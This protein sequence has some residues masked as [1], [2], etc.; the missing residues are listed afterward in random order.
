MTAPQK[1]PNA[2]AEFDFAPFGFHKATAGR[3]ID[4]VS[5]VL[6]L[7][8]PMAIGL[9]LGL[10][11]G[12]GL[13]LMM[14]PV[15]SATTSVLVSKKASVP[16]NN[17][18]AN[19]YGE[20]GDHVQL[21]QTDLIV[22]RAFKDH[23]LNEIPALANAYDPLR[24]VT[25]GLSVS[26]SAGQESSFDNVLSITYLH[27]DK[28]IAR[29]V[30]QAM[31]EA[32]RDYLED[33]RDENAQ[34]LYKSLL[35]RQQQLENDVKSLEAE[36]QKFRHDAPVF[37]KASP[38]VSING[39]PAPAQ[40]QYETELASI[41]TAQNENLRKR[42]S[43]QAR[44]ATLDRKLKDNASREELEF[45]VMHSLSTGTAGAGGGNGGG[46]ASIAG[47]PEKGALD[48]QL[49]TARLLEQRLLHSLGDDHTQVRNVRRQINT[50]LDF[51]T[52][53]GL[54]PPDLKQTGKG[55][56]SS[57][58]AALGLDLVSV[59][60]DTLQGQL[61]EL[62]LDNQNLALL[63][64]DA[65]KK[66][67]QAEMFEVEDQRRK[68]EI[69]QKKQQLER[70]FDQI[71]E[72]DITRG[73]E[74]YRLQQI[75]QVRIE[76]SMKRVI[77]LVGTCGVMGI[78]IIFCLAYF[79][80]WYDTSLK[81]LDDV[82]T[83]THEPLMGSVPTFSSSTDL[84]RIAQQRGLSPALCYYHR[85]GSREAEAYRSVRTTLF[86]SMREDH[87]VVQV[88]SA[89]P[90][91]GK[92]TT[93][94]NL[95]IAIAQSGK[96]VLLVDC[97][98]RRPTQ[99]TLFQVPQEVGLTDVLLREIDWQNAVRPTQIENLSLMTAGLC[100]ENPAELLSTG[101]LQVMLRRAREEYDVVLLDSPP[102]LAVSD[103]CIISP[104]ADGLLLVVRMK[105]TKRA[106]VQRVHETLQSHGVQVYGVIAN[107]FQPT[108]SGESGY[109][110]DSYGTYYRE[111]QT[112]AASKAK[113]AYVPQ[114]AGK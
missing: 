13:Y 75:S 60:R 77:K 25:E 97:D 46:G 15:Y 92:S 66:A 94:A 81:T 37:L 106:T 31:V 19:R 42:S 27:P 107:D 6:S 36:Y 52:R 4:I 41:E 35:E 54:T 21:I 61:K 1:Q 7:W 80:E 99:H 45:W 22:E 91:E 57:R 51:Y 93:A 95:A 5:F 18:E 3:S 113:S 87:K 38:I 84:D 114:T 55:P 90:G 58:S 16:A 32:Y 9:F 30:V 50:I 105:K 74:G 2:A 108:T 47:P 73:Q 82:T 79:R 85:P 64:T 28:R 39:M 112:P 63:H 111:N 23:G 44:L 69:A 14:G 12:V 40:N 110:Y 29:A 10:L 48:S 101:T 65:Q 83:F 17:G 67:K 86:V 96:K 8:K 88:S 53:Q 78:A 62:E 103:P 104:H 76:R 102:I 68:D 70:M 71:A 59:Y 24:E 11:V 72:Y 49:L 26:R 89:A 20:R 33:T 98:L 109:D 34:Q 100:P 43:I 56:I